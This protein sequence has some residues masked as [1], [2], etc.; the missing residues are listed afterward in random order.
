MD[1]ASPPDDRSASN[2]KGTDKGR[3]AEPGGL[4]PASGN[5]TGKS[6]PVDL[7]AATPSSGNGTDRSPVELGAVTPPAD[8]RTAR[9]DKATEENRP[10]ELGAVAPAAG[11]PDS[12]AAADGTESLRP[13]EA[14]IK[15]GSRARRIALAVLLAAG[16]TGIAAAGV[17]GW[18]I[19]AQKDATV[20]APAQVAGLRLDD[21]ENGRSTA[22]YLQTA[23]AAEIDLDH[24]VAAAYAD[25][26]GHDI[27]FAGGTG[28]IWRP[29]DDLDA[30]IA[31]VSDAQGA[32]THVHEVPAG[33]LGGTVKCGKTATDGGDMA[34]CG[35][36]DHGSVALALF[37]NRSEDDA[38]GLILTIRQAAQ[39]RD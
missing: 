2:G 25:S 39:K 5:G 12:E 27:L 17:T 1:P 33:P 36:A 8:E 32:V 6:G 13:G 11:G 9:G 19:V 35:W 28:L 38:A 20:S 31:M 10:I 3:P 21:S 18:R 29:G 26:S 14:A 24:A 7:G 22:D 23:L 37:P 16:V 30:A 34:V 4:T 15:S